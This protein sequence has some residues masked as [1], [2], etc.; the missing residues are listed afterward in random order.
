MSKRVFVVTGVNRGI[1]KSIA[2]YLHSK[3]NVVIG[4]DKELSEKCTDYKRICIDIT[5]ETE[6]KSVCGEIKN[7][8]K[9]I[10]GLVNCA[11]VTFPSTLKNY[12]TENWFKTMSVNLT[13]PFLI[14]ENLKDV[15]VDDTGAIVNIS[16]LNGKLSFPNNPAYVS[17]KTGLDGLTRSYA[18]ELGVRGIRVNS[19]APGYIKT[20][21]TGES[22]SNPEK[23]KKRADRAMLKRWGVPK[24]I[25]GPVEFLLSTKSLFITGQTIY[26]DGGWSVKGF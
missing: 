19:I 16:S 7:Q 4:L 10:D 13:A 26:V 5:D 15:L 6:L 11:G 12:P 22:W 23:R 24:D 2:D 14:I 18:L 17:S 1:G 21:M 20:E 25:C 9:N 3:N 8:F